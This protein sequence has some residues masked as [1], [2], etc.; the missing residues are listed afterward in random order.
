VANS[1]F[2]AW[3]PEAWSDQLRTRLFCLR[4]ADV[5][6]ILGALDAAG[7]RPCLA[8]GWGIDALLGRETR[9]HDDV[10]VIIVPGTEEMAQQALAELGYC[11]VRTGVAAGPYMPVRSVVRDAPGRTVDLL[12]LALHSLDRPPTSDPSTAS[13]EPVVAGTVAGQTVR[14]LSAAV[15]MMFHEGYDLGPVQT[16]DVRLL[17]SRFALDGGRGAGQRHLSGDS[18]A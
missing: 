8:G 17:R 9:R 18:S 6:L 5:H 3:L 16:N 2:V 15:Q 14:C 4:A 11:E 7:C 10:D 12:P 13:E 1:R